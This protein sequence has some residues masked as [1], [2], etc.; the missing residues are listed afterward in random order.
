MLLS[1]KYMPTSQRIEVGVLK[2]RIIS[3][4]TGTARGKCVI[5]V[6]VYHIHAISKGTRKTTKLTNS[7]KTNMI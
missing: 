2:I 3:K 6:L 4:S 5:T 1:L 7:V